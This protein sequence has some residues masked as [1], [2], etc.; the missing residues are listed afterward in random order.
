MND[1]QDIKR[2]RER[3]NMGKNME[4]VLHH[5]RSRLKDE[6]HWMEKYNSMD[7]GQYEDGDDKITEGIIEAL[8]YSI[9]Q[10]EELEPPS[11]NSLK[12]LRKK[13]LSK[14]KA[15]KNLNSILGRDNETNE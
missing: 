13:G 5:L 3:V 2:I 14:K 4:Q 9:K 15:I 12:H 8:E 11:N 6:E 10:I 1:Q 7:A